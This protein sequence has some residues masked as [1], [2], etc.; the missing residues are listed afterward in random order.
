MSKKMRKSGRTEGGD[1]EEPTLS[2]VQLLSVATCRITNSRLHSDRKSLVCPAQRYL[3][4][5]GHEIRSLGWLPA[6]LDRCPGQKCAKCQKL[7]RRQPAQATA[8][9]EEDEQVPTAASNQSQWQRCGCTPY[10][11]VAKAFSLALAH[12]SLTLL[13]HLAHLPAAVTLHLSNRRSLD[14]SVRQTVGQPVGLQKEPGAHRITC[15]ITSPQHRLR[16]HGQNK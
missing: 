13:S 12:S 2:S 5:I 7:I 1:S 11:A 9:C 4:T 10:E 8:N 15:L 14:S 6:P 3:P 16:L